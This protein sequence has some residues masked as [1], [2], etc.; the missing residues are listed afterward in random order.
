ML[1][2][3]NILA[4]VGGGITPR[5][6]PTNVMIWDDE[7][8]KCIAELSFLSEVRSVRL[9]RDRIVVCQES[10]ISVYNFADLKLL[11]TITTGANARGLVSLSSHP[12][13]TVLACP[14][15]QSGK[16]R[17]DLYDRRATKFICAHDSPLAALELSLDGRILATASER[18]TLIRVWNTAT[19]YILQE[20]RRGL[21]AATIFSISISKSCDYLAVSSDKGTVH[22]FAL[23]C[24]TPLVASEN[25]RPELQKE[26]GNLGQNQSSVFASIKNFVPLP[27]YFNSEWSLA[28]FKL[29][30]DSWSVVAFAEDCTHTLSI[31]NKKGS[32]YRVE[33]DPLKGGPCTEKNHENILKG[34]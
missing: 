33:F 25:E 4:L 12:D 6:P 2:R 9:R 29:T 30:E 21:D 1:F 8:A 34:E 3:C 28:Q 26:G 15:L 14:G 27:N 17:V 19:G 24:F 5:F 11:H 16:V 23:R 18:G 22:I 7:K 13:F 10:K 32:F 31:L 20:L